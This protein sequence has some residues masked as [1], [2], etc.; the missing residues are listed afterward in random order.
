MAVLLW[1]LFE[2]YYLSNRSTTN[3]D[4]LHVERYY[5]LVCMATEHNCFVNPYCS[6]VLTICIPYIQYNTSLNAEY[7]VISGPASPVRPCMRVCVRRNGCGTYLWRI[8]GV[9]VRAKLAAA[10]TSCVFRVA[11]KLSSRRKGVG[12]STYVRLYIHVHRTRPFFQGRAHAQ[13]KTV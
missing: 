13:P 1:Q 3:L 5:I 6:Y 12:P 2:Y 9:C 4:T 8:V 11:W 7:C 10:M